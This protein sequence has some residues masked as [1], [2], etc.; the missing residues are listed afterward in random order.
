MKTINID[1]KKYIEITKEEYFANKGKEGYIER[2]EGPCKDLKKI[3][4]Y[5]LNNNY[6]KITPNITINGSHMTSEWYDYLSKTCGAIAV[7][8]YSDD[9]CF[10]AVKELTDRGMDQVNI[11]CMLSAQTFDKCMNLID[12][13][14]TDKRLEKLNAVVF[15]MLKPRGRG[16]KFSRV[17]D[18]QYS[19]FVKK[20][21]ESKI[22]W[23]M[24][25]CGAGRLLKEDIPEQV[26]KYITPCESTRESCY[27]NVDG[28][29]FPCSFAEDGEGIDVT[30]VDDFIKDVWMNEEICQWRQNLLDNNC[31]C[32]IYKV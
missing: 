29:F 3:M 11:H 12:K 25:S 6:Q 10:N 7:S 19:T 16:E 14:Q 21:F 8:L 13:V 30:K 27:M 4:D 24:D 32:P 17:S 31:N 22:N 15:L 1:R 26:K 18:E 20:L 23:G 9:N 5:C 28:K 2:D